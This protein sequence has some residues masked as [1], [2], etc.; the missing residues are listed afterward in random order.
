[1]Y[2][3]RL[4]GFLTPKSEIKPIGEETWHGIEQLMLTLAAEKKLLRTEEMVIV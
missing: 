3:S 2:S 1:M 4:H